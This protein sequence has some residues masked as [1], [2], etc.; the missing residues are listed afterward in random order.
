MAGPGGS[1]EQ[2]TVLAEADSNAAEGGEALH[3]AAKALEGEAALAVGGVLLEAGARAGL[4]GRHGR[5]SDRPI[6]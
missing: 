2:R 5:S 4:D 1:V 3:Q 6:H